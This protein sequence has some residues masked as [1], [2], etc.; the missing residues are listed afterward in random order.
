MRTIV[1]LA[2][3]ALA[4]CQMGPS[5]REV[6]A[7]LVGRP[8]SDALRAFGAPNRVIDAD[9][10]RFLAYDD[11]GVN[12]VPTAPYGFGY[13]YPVAVPL[14]RTCVTTL[15]VAGGT[16]RSWTLRGNACE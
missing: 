8:E 6:L 10:R 7:S 14:V 13:F 16:I 5:R 4:G 15:E 3:L 1:I 2:V 12:Y 11:S 9:G